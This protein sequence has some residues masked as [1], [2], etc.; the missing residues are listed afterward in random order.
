MVFPADFVWGTATSA[1]QIEGGWDA[2]GKYP[3]IWD[4][5]CRRPGAVARGESGDLACNHYHRWNEDLELLTFLGVK[6]YRF[7]TSW[8]R[9]LPAGTGDVNRPG[10]DFYDRLVDGLLERG[11]EPWLTLYH[12]DLPEALQAQGGWL[13]SLSPAWFTHYTQVVVD[14]LGDRVK[15]WITFNEPQVFIHSGYAL[16]D[17]APGLKENLP[18]TL[19]AA[20][21][22]LLAHGRSCQEIRSRARITPL[23]GWAPAGRAYTP[24]DSNPENCEAARD[25]TFTVQDDTVF[26]D[27]WWSD[28]VLLGHYPESGLRRYGKAVPPHG[29]HDLETMCQPLDF[30][31]VNYYFSWNR[32]RMGSCGPEEV[33]FP[34]G[35]P[36]TLMDWPVTPEVLYYGPLWLH[37]RYGKPLVISENGLSLPDW[38]SQDGR[39]HDPQRVDYLKRHLRELE[40]VLADG[41]PVI[42]YFHWSL[43]DNFEWNS[44]YKHRFGLIHVDFPTGTRTPKDS[45]DWF[46]T[47]LATN[48]CT[49]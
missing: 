29:A 5:F 42:G 22:V 33:P 47:V 10:L 6:A 24:V 12:W 36:R 23:I 16:G 39:V 17:H 35:F 19:L 32:V 34:E 21:H 46:R 38:V 8:S 20:Q 9:I 49:L 25:R 4:T 11:I 13:N 28:P 27:V 18:E 31:A 30:Y 7:S 26:N 2:D 14:R 1:Y 3:S 45:A 15:H 43:M 48:G 44:G 40:R 37:Q 41:I